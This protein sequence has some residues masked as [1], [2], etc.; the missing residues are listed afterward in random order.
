VGSL[1][2]LVIELRIVLGVK[3]FRCLNGAGGTERMIGECVEQ[4][5]IW[6]QLH[7]EKG[8]NM[9]KIM[10]ADGK[11]YGPISLEQFSQ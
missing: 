10:G 9:Y 11:E 2:I 7:Q 4:Q 1:C 8:S 5:K 6:P 3:V